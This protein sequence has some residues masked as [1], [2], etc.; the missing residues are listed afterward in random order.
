[1]QPSPQRRGWL[2]GQRACVD[3]Q[4][5][6]LSHNP[7]CLFGGIH[8]SAMMTNLNADKRKTLHCHDVTENGRRRNIASFFL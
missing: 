2:D 3:D 1:M 4:Q 7:A 8:F 6:R 5:E